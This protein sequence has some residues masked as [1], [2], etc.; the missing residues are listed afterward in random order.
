M[1]AAAT[2]SMAALLLWAA[3][4]AAEDGAICGTGAS[5]RVDPADSTAFATLADAV[6]AATPGAALDVAAGTVDAADV[7][8]ASVL[9]RGDAAGTTLVGSGLDDLHV[10]AAGVCLR[11]FT[12]RGDGTDG[13]VTVGADGLAVDGVQ[14]EGTPGAGIILR[15]TEGASLSD[16]VVEGA[17]V[18]ALVI[19]DSPDVHVASAD[20][21]SGARGVHAVRSDGLTLSGVSVHGVSEDGIVLEE[22]SGA[23]VTGATLRDGVWGLWVLRSS[24]VHVADLDAAGFH[25]LGVRADGAHGLTIEGGLIHDGAP[26][27]NDAVHVAGSTDVTV[28]GLAVAD[29]PLNGIY[30]K[31]SSSVTLSG[32]DIQRVTRGIHVLES[33]DAHISGNRLA[34]TS[35]NGLVLE[36]MTGPAD[37]DGNRL[38]DNTWSLWLLNA[39][40]VQVT[41]TSV[42]SWR[43][44]GLRVEGS[45]R[46]ALSGLTL[47]DGPSPATNFAL[48]ILQSK[49]VTVT[50]SEILNARIDGVLARDVTGLRFTGNAVHDVGRGM[51]LIDV[52][53][54]L[55]SGNRFD[56]MADNGI[57]V[58]PGRNVTVADNTL[59]AG[60]I[61]IWLRAGAADAGNVVRGNQVSGFTSSGISLDL[62]ATGVLV[63]G[64]TVTGSFRGLKVLDGG[65]S[66]PSTV[67]AGNSFVGNDVVGN[68]YGVWSDNTRGSNLVQGGEVHGS[69]ACDFWLANATVL[70]LDGV[71]L[72]TGATTNDLSKLDVVSVAGPLTQPCR[73]GAGGPPLALVPATIGDQECSSTEWHFSITGV[74]SR[75]QAP[76]WIV[77][78]FSDGSQEHVAFG[79]LSG[80][81]AHYTTRLHLG[82]DVVAAT[83]ALPPSWTGQ[84][85]LSHG[86]CGGAA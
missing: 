13:L 33:G 47:G 11:G 9:V 83:A 80:K 59:S 71:G 17:G 63:Q 6:A 40:D 16:V 46:V 65:G 24:D 67:T 7:S 42:D 3:P 12:L 4:A 41:D 56:R 66:T 55:V 62:G 34:D 73:S 82:E 30:V 60:R 49:A 27:A 45:E 52:R 86:P 19:T 18:N 29:V 20:L 14:V 2:L 44:R 84:F 21:S 8:I 10:S 1:T 36:D 5:L 57:V 69:T 23:D 54:I 50:G 48:E 70:R 78:T 74:K 58:E 37:L 72:G 22:L 79:K 81:T 77:V 28:S 31:G 85:V 53:D 35:E 75:G 26:G 51:H 39:D 25:D 32:N 43:D 61:G 76:N 68:T 38:S 15:D 64:N